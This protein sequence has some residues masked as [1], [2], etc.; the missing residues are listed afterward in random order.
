ML[1]C[2]LPVIDWCRPGNSCDRTRSRIGPTSPRF[3]HRTETRPPVAGRGPMPASSRVPGSFRLDTSTM[4]RPSGFTWFPTHR[5]SQTSSSRQVSCR[6]FRGREPCNRKA[7]LWCRLGTYRVE[8][9]RAD[10]TRAAASSAIRRESPDQQPLRCRMWIVRT[11]LA[12]DR[13]QCPRLPIHL[14]GDGQHRPEAREQVEHSIARRGEP[15][16]NIFDE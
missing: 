9:P 5:N 3:L 4:I 11:S 1:P 14:L 6:P 2:F 7:D 13:F 8:R 15:T 10:Q 12:R 16:Q